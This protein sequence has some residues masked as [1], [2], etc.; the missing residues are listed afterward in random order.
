MIRDMAPRSLRPDEDPLQGDDARLWDA[1][2]EAVGPAGILVAI[3]TRLGED[4]RRH[5]SAE[6]V[7][8]ETLL[9][10]WRD[11]GHC[12]WRGVPAFRKWLLR[13]A[14]NRIRDLADEIAAEKRGGSA[15]RIPL[16]EDLGIPRRGVFAG[17]TDTTT[18]QRAAMDKERAEAMLAALAALP[19][20]LRTVVRL[21]LFEDMSMEE[22][23]R[24]LG[25]HA[26][27]ARRRFRKG[28]DEYYRRIRS[29][30][31]TPPREGKGRQGAPAIPL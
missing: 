1:V 28:C 8:Q 25:I 18:P 31:T 12:A 5:V 13:V 22:V 16:A 27:A 26:Q 3:D 17:P 29:A 14:T 23:G 21:G 2:I 20:E 19:E 10:A 9:H 30:L 11:R 6:D 15:V 24:Q 4:L 7:W